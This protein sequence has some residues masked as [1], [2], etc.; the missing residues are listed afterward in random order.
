YLSEMTDMPPLGAGQEVDVE[1][2][3]S[4]GEY[5]PVVVPTSVKVVG[6]APM[7]KAQAVSIEALLSGRN[8]SQFVEL[9]G[10]VRSVRF[11]SESQQYLMDLVTGGERFTAYAKKLPVS[12]T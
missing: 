7:P 2:I 4:P 6:Q 10:I 9:S 3:T 12:G 8:D 11:E 1:G 5:A